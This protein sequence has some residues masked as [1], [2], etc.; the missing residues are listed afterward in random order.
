[1]LILVELSEVVGFCDFHVLGLGHRHG[2]VQ[3]TQFSEVFFG[4]SACS[5][6][7]LFVARQV[8]VSWTMGKRDMRVILEERL[9]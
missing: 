9:M 4:F 7:G 3:A 2:G 6:V 8:L 1:M 5:S